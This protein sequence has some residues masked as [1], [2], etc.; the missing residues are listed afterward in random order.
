MNNEDRE[1]TQV[2]LILYKD[3]LEKIDRIWKRM[4]LKN[5]SELIRIELDRLIEEYGEEI[6]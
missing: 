1:T 4:Y 6:K 3:Q 2:N 5:R